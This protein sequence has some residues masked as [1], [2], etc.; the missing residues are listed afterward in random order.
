MS[1]QIHQ[2]S[3]A[4]RDLGQLAEFIRQGRPRAALRFLRAARSTMESLAAMP[5]MG[6]ACETNNPA[7]AGLRF[8]RISGFPA[9][10][11]FYRPME[12]G[13]EVL[14]VLHSARDLEAIFPNE[15]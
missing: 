7:L 4:I 9:F 5:E 14:R 10:L 12:G 6:P 1:G 2:H 15:T 11:I 3:T 13:I 8:F